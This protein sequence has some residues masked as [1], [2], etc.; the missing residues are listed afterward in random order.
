MILEKLETLLIF[1]QQKLTV[2]DTFFNKKLKDLE[3]L[4]SSNNSDENL[5]EID[6][7]HILIVDDIQ[8]NR[9]LVSRHLKADG[10]KYQRLLMAKEALDL[11]RMKNLILFY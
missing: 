4:I 10:H 9:E 6:T 8:I 2:E 3:K 1:Q 7:G 5:N 11:M